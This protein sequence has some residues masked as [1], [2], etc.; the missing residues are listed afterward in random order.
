[1]PSLVFSPDDVDSDL[2]FFAGVRYTNQ[3]KIKNYS[4]YDLEMDLLR[5]QIVLTSSGPESLSDDDE[6]FFFFGIVNSIR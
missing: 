3:N 1:M 2:A 4:I 6:M 5:G